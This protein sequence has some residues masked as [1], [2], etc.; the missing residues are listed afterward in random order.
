MIS[1]EYLKFILD[2]VFSAESIL[3]NVRAY[4]K[5]LKKVFEVQGTL[6]LYPNNEVTCFKYKNLTFFNPDFE[7]LAK[8][9]IEINLRHLHPSLV[10]VMNSLEQD[11][12]EIGLNK[13]RMEAYIKRACAYY[14]CNLHSTIVNIGLIHYSNQALNYFVY[15]SLPD[16]F[17]V[18]N[19]HF[20]EIFHDCKKP[21]LSECSTKTS[22][23]NLENLFKDNAKKFQANEEST[24]N[25]FKQ[26]MF[27]VNILG[28]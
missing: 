4:H 18:N 20:H 19:N 11:F 24:V 6:V 22:K 28:M 8:N 12:N 21:L 9:K 5:G 27:K 13:R 2:N 15:L 1:N 25:I 16:C 10:P 23:E 14:A 17:I 7:K 26:F 3:E